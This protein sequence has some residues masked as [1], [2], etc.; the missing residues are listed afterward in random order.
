MPSIVGA[1]TQITV[2][3]NGFLWIQTEIIL[4]FLIVQPCLVALSAYQ[5]LVHCEGYCIPSKEFLPTVVD[6]I[7][8]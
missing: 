6:I 1:Y 5:T 2:M 7:V 3:L 8:I 4:S